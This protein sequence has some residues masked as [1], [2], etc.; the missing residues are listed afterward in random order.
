MEI[1]N[2]KLGDEIEIL[3]L[4]ELVF[5]RPMSLSYW[6]WR[7]ENNPAGKHMIKLMWDGRKLV[8]HYAVSPVLLRVHDE[9][10]LSALSMTTMT[11]PEYVG[12]GIFGDLANALYDELENDMGVVAIW[13]YPNSNS[14]YG[15][16]KNLGWK[17]VGVLHV[18]SSTMDSIT[19]NKIDGIN[20]VYSFTESNTTVFNTIISAFPVSVLRNPTYLNWRYIENPTSSY[21]IFEVKNDGE[22]EIIVSKLYPSQNSPGTWEIFIVEF[23]MKSAKR[24]K[25]VLSHLVDFYK[26]PISRTNI[27]LSLWDERHIQLE[28]FGF[29]PLGKQT[30][31]GVRCHESNIGLLCDLRNWYYSFGDSDVY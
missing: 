1:R 30:F 11:H 25:Q 5:K 23:G 16:I 7:F 2:Y 20:Q 27:W 21:Q 19:A 6:K 22:P 14:H 4:F 17:D 24:I 9:E 31:L 3:K 8:G 15:F 13:G 12:L 29:A 18:L 10:K 28:R 26:K